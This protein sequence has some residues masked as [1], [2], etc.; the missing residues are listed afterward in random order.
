LK[1]ISKIKTWLSFNKEVVGI[2]VVLS[3]VM[4][5]YYQINSK[6]QEFETKVY[7]EQVKLK[8]L[9]FDK[10]Y[11]SDIYNVKRK[12]DKIIFEIDYEYQ[13]KDYQNSTIL[14]W[15]FVTPELEKILEK[16]DFEKLIVRCNKDN[17]EQIMVYI[18]NNH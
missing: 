3:I 5:I 7:T 11:S 2:I 18:N 15:E 9:E 13:D 6:R 10:I 16:R 14:Y 4:L 17:P 12:L 8:K 1:I